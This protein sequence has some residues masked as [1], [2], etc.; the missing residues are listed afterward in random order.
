MGWNSF[1]YHFSLPARSPY[2]HN[3]SNFPNKISECVMI[4]L[5]GK[6]EINHSV[7]L[8]R[9]AFIVTVHFTSLQTYITGQSN[10]NSL[11]GP[12]HPKGP[13]TL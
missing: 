9:I 7:I 3:H 1:K 11:K 2:G 10:L 4:L 12:I 6:D 5:F 8:Q 13:H